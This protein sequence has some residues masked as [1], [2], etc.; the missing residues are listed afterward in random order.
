MTERRARTGGARREV[1]EELGRARGEV[2]HV[3]G[4]RPR[5]AEVSAAAEVGRRAA[6]GAPQGVLVQ[7]NVGDETS[8]SGVNVA[9]DL[10]LLF[11]DGVLIEQV[12]VNLIENALKYTPAGAPLKLSAAVEAGSM[13]VPARSTGLGCGATMKYTWPARRLPAPEF[14]P[15]CCAV[16]TSMPA[17]RGT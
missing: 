14:H 11:I 7:V 9:D 6:P 5:G 3:G 10:P 15:R 8:K 17:R 12:V 4:A 2:L 16:G 1:E 13:R